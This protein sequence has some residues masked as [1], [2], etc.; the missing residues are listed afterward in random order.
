MNRSE[1]VEVPVDEINLLTTIIS[2]AASGSS[3]R[4]LLF[5]C[6]YIKISSMPDI[7]T[8]KKNIQELIKSMDA[9]GN[10]HY[11]SVE[12]LTEPYVSHCFSESP[13]IS[14]SSIPTVQW[15][16]LGGMEEARREVYDLISIPLKFNTNNCS[17]LGKKRIF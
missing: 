10:S 12:Q 17:K 13:F 9:I 2:R 6:K 16:D 15:D 3:K 1:C 11:N 7:E 8:L 5:L 4:Q 14:T